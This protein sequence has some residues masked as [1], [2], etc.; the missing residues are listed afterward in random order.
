[1]L[2]PGT[3]RLGAC[4]TGAA[5]ARRSLDEIVARAEADLAFRAAL[6]ADL[7]ATLKLE[8]YEPDR[9]VVEEL[10]RRFSDSSSAPSRVR[11][12]TTW[13]RTRGRESAPRVEPAEGRRRADRP[14]RCSGPSGSH[15]SGRGRTRT[16]RACGSASSTR[17]SRR[18][19]RSSA[20]RERRGDRVGENDEPIVTEDREGDLSGHGTACAGIVRALAPECA[21]SSVRVL[22]Q[23]FKGSGN[24]LLAGLRH[25]VDAGLRPDQHEPLDDE[26]ALRGDPPRARRQRVLPAHRARRIGAQHARRE[27]PVEVLL[28]DLG[29]EPRGGGPAR[30][31]LQPEPAGRVLRP[32]RERRGRLAGRPLADRLREQLRHAAHDAGSARSSSRSIPS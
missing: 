4:R 25:A 28:G 10:K 7:E 29:R 18:I 3:R 6:I 2:P 12:W 30:L 14:A 1:M 17:E 15:A 31:L 27:L 5:A 26:E 11:P 8:G 9:R 13:S 19:T 22:G 21:I 16:E 32:R 24:V 23:G 20:A